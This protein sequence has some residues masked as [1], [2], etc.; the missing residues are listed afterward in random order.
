MDNSI[1]WDLFGKA[2]ILIK[3]LIADN[4]FQSKDQALGSD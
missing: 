1:E 4:A 2:H 3:G